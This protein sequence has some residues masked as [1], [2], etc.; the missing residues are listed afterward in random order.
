MF[1]LKP[2]VSYYALSIAISIV[3]AIFAI[4]IV[5]VFGSMLAGDASDITK[6]KGGWRAV[7]R[8]GAGMVLL[9]VIGSVAV[10]FLVSNWIMPPLCRWVGT[11]KHAV[12]Y[13]PAQGQ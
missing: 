5:T 11:D 8:G 6:T 3:V 4:L 2:G 7:A 9:L 1:S 10:T 13:A 12:H